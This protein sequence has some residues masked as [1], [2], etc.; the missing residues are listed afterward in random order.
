LRLTCDP[1]V[2]FSEYFWPWLLIW[3]TDLKT[4]Y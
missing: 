3:M 1:F 2:D 4:K